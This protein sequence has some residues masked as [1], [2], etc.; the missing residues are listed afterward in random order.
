MLPITMAA[1]GDT[2]LIKRIAG[3][4]EM[5]RHL[6]E[7]GLVEG[8]HIKVRNE[9]EASLCQISYDEAMQEYRVQPTARKCV[10][11]RSGQPLGPHR[12][13]CL[14]RGTELTIADSGDKFRLA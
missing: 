7:L 14:P 10:H 9:E 8:D 12:L 5:R 4:D 11:M 2:V 6:N 3:K 13:Y 1:P